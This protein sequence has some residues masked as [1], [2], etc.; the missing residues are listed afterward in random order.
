M[1][2]F[3]LALALVALV[4]GGCAGNPD[5]QFSKDITTITPIEPPTFL[6]PDVAGLFGKANFSARVEVQKGV[7]GTRLPLAGQLFGRAGNLFFYGCRATR[8]T[9]HLHRPERALGWSHANGIFVE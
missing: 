8:Q 4:F 9:R 6:N 7:A 2:K 1:K 3:H 5:K